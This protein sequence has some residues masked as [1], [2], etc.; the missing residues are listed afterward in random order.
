MSFK[1]KLLEFDGTPLKE[2]VAKIN[3]YYGSSVEI[4]SPVMEN[5]P[6]SSPF[7]LGKQ[8]LEDVIDILGETFNMKVEKKDG[9]ILLSGNGCE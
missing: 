2:V 4:V 5:C 1:T 3:D 8:S 7:D 6:V 9:K